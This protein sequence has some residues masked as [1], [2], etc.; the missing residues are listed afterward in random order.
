MWLWEHARN[1]KRVLGE[2]T[3]DNEVHGANMVPIW[4]WE[5]PGEPRVGPMNFAI[6]DC[7]WHKISKIMTIDKCTN[8]MQQIRLSF[9]VTTGLVI[10]V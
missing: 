4:G 10:D 6:W 3:S 9:C 1:N 7:T 5:D 8:I 2:H